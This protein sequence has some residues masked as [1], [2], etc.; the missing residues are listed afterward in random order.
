MRIALAKPPATYAD[1]YRRP[2]LGLAYLTSYLK[3]R[4]FDAKIFDAY[5]HGWSEDDLVARIAAFKPDLVGFSAMT[6]EINRSAQIAARLKADLGVPIAIGGCHLTALPAETL[7]EFPVFDYGVY[8][9]GE[10]SFC[11]LAQC[12][13]DGEVG[14]AGSLRGL[15]LRRGG[16][17]VTTEAAPVLSAEEVNDMPLPDFGDYYGSDP[18]ALAGKDSCYVLMTSRGCPYRCAFCMQVL[19]RKVR[20]RSAENVCR[21]MEQAIARHGAHTF[22]FYDDILLSDCK[23][24]RDLLNLMIERGLPKRAGW[25]GL[26]RADIVRPDLLALAKRAGCFRLGLGVE[27]GDDGVLKAIGKGITVDEVR[28]AVRAIKDAGMAVDAYFILGHPGETGETVKRTID[29]AAELD[30]DMIAVGLMVPYPGTRIFEMAN[31]GECGYRLLSRD[32][33]QYDK[34]GGRVL[35]VSGLPYR[36]LEK[37]QVRALANF[38]V[39]NLKVRAAIGYFWRRR[40][41][42]RFLIAKR[43]ARLLGGG[44]SAAD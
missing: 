32:W 6:H 26:T 10:K 39:K 12:L 38:Y 2:V 42:V 30:T 11:E 28:R 44:R 17:V 41:A 13:A 1:W 8:G 3:A 19:G 21:E 23:E 27:S 25:C 40:R 37:M 5:Y 15:V 9:E 35:E 31:R 14:R 18:K 4:G 16:R 34:Y 43:I 22:D 36:E 33:S 24:S 7:E 29:L 20:R